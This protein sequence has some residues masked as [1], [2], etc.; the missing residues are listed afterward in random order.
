MRRPTGWLLAIVLS[1][2]ATAAA[3]EPL[4]VLSTGAFK[5]VLLVALP[6]FEA[7]GRKVEVVTD[8]AGGVARRI[9]AGESFDLVIASPA[10]L[11]PLQASGKVA[12]P[13]QDIARVG[14][15]VAVRAGAPRPDI[16]TVEA[17]K[18]TLLAAQHVAFV[19]PASGGTSGIYLSGL[20]D[21]LGIGGPV[22][23][24]AVLV[25]G[26]Y[27]AEKITTGEADL[28]VQQISELLPVR[29]VEFIGPLPA[30]IQ[31]YTVYAAA[32]APGSR[33]ADAAR[34]LIA[35]LRNEAGVAAI[36]AKGMEPAF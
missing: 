9:E 26:G 13:I 21:R 32:L 16:A 1:A 33:E 15:G 14:V 20:L 18:R 6:D 17:F 27:A 8:T 29:G 7:S 28:A 31:N 36:R 19:D 35:R 10:A 34:A 2:S 12:G 11:A 25:K 4:K 30:E 3:A 23:D 5:Q 24:K 22:K